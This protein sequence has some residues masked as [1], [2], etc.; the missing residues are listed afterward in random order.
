[1]FYRSAFRKLCEASAGLPLTI[2]LFDVAVKQMAIA[3]NSIKN[4][5]TQIQRCSN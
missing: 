2:R 3:I 4:H 1:V 5:I